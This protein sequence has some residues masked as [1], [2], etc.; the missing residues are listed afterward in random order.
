MYLYIVCT[1][2]ISLLNFSMTSFQSIPAQ[3]QRVSILCFS[4]CTFTSTIYTC[5]H[6]NYIS[7]HILHDTC[8][9]LPAQP[10]VST[11][12]S[13]C[14]CIQCSS[15]MYMYIS[16]NILHDTLSISTCTTTVGKYSFFMHIN[17]STLYVLYISS[18]ILHDFFSINTGT[19]TAGK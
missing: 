8:T 7:F 13:Y 19:D 9:S 16:L 18:Q 14:T 4:S 2:Y 6:N 10:Q 5:I 1:V 15:S 12:F 17:T 3:P 11:L